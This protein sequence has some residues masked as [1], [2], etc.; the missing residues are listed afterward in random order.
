MLVEAPEGEIIE[1]DNR[2]FWRKKA[3]YI[4]FPFRSGAQQHPHPPPPAPGK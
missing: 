4:N 3:W 2:K 1:A